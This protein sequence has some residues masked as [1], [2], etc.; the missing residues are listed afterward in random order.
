MYG[1]KQ[2]PNCWNHK[3]DNLLKSFEMK[4]SPA[5]DCLYIGQRNDEII[6]LLLYV[7]DGLVISKS[8][9]ILDSFLN[10]LMNTFEIK[11]YEP[12]YFIGFEIERN[13]AKKSLRLHQFEYINKF[14]DRFQMNDAKEVS[15]LM[16]PVRYSRT[17]CPTG[18]LFKNN[19]FNDN[20]RKGRNEE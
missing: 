8:K 19:V 2:S 10:D 3:F 17:M 14:I 18:R 6:Y 11:I 20:R 4:L 5:D 9:L 12:R 16:D 1:L 15:V 13:R 7:D